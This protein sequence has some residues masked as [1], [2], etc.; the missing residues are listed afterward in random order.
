MVSAKQMVELADANINNEY[1]QTIE[2]IVKRRAE[3]G[4]FYA[5]LWE[6]TPTSMDT[7]LI[8]ADLYDVDTYNH[9]RRMGYTLVTEEGANGDVTLYI[10]WGFASETALKTAIKFGEE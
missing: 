1:L 5:Q 7:A 9:V 3:K 10:G 2:Q 8:F 6:G 4:R